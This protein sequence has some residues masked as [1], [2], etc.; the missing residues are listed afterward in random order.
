MKKIMGTLTGTGATINVE[1]GFK[2]DYVRIIN[3]TTFTQVECFFTTVTTAPSAASHS[4]Q[5]VETVTAHGFN[6]E[7]DGDR[8]AMASAAAGLAQYAGSPGLESTGFTIG[9]SA[10][11]NVNTNVIVWEAVQMD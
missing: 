1:C 4:Q 10:V 5:I 9:A 3:K 7:A 11:P 2:P 8:T 6:I